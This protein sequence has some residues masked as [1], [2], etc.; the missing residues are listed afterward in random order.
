MVYPLIIEGNIVIQFD[1]DEYSMST[2]SYWHLKKDM[3]YKWKSWL[4]NDALFCKLVKKMSVE[5]ILFSMHSSDI[6]V[7]IFFELKF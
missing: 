6:G 4:L 2:L 5:D 1:D 3:C 7:A